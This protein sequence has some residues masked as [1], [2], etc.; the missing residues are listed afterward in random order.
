MTSYYF[1][2][3]TR[4]PLILAA[5]HGQE[6]KS[7]ASAGQAIM[8]LIM[9]R[10][11]RALADRLARRPLTITRCT[12]SSPHPGRALHRSPSAHTSPIGVPF[13]LF[14]GIFNLTVHLA[15]L[16]RGQR[17]LHGRT[18]QARVRRARHRHRHSARSSGSWASGKYLYQLVPQHRPTRRGGDVPRL[19]GLARCARR[20]SRSSETARASPTTT[21]TPTGRAERSEGRHRA[22]TVPKPKHR[23]VT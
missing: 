21:K 9:T 19:V 8:L 3:V 12:A 13:F 1:L 17:L 10:G 23:Q 15:V 20:R 5:P 4:E 6:I 7:F 18:R 2:K 11:Y 16:E 22:S 14:V